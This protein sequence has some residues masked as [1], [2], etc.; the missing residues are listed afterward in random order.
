M[1]NQQESS[2][3]QPE[4]NDVNTVK[5]LL[6]YLLL[7]LEREIT[8]AQ[9]YD[10]C[11]GREIINYFFYQDAVNDLYETGA[12]LK[13]HDAA[14]AEIIVLSSKG[15]SCARQFGTYV[16][17][18]FRRLLLTEAI[19]FF[20][21]ER[22]KSE[23]S[24]EYIKLKKGWHVHLRCLDVGDDLMEMKLYAPDEEQAKLIA[25]KVAMNPVAFYGNVLGFILD[26]EPIRI[27]PEE[28]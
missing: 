28:L 12:L 8:P 4:L 18:Y 11:V 7:K 5:F 15:A 6:C 16:P 17:R 23:I 13:A 2:S 25:K 21:N 19:T 24:I 10:I 22:I 14:G 20:Y 3:A 26:N 27:E 9:L 1:I